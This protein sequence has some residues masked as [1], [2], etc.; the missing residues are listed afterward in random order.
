MANSPRMFQHLEDEKS[1]IKED[2]GIMGKIGM[3]VVAIARVV[4]HFL[5]Q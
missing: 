3:W 1:A 2:F 4:G 5:L